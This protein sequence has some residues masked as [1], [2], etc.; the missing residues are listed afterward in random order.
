MLSIIRLMLERRPHAH[1]LFWRTPTLV[2]FVLQPF[3]IMGNSLAGG[4]NIGGFTAPQQAAPQPSYTQI[5]T[6]FDGGGFAGGGF[7]G[8]FGGGGE[9]F[10][11]CPC[12]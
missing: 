3:N 12:L 8:G 2:C 5:N 11:G 1:P 6:G 10:S 7:G 9:C 4:L